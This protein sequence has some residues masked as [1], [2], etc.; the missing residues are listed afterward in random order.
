[1]FYLVE[2]S[3]DEEVTLLFDRIPLNRSDDIGV[4]SDFKRFVSVLVPDDDRAVI[5]SAG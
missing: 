2:A 4:L 1:M 3:G 5:Q